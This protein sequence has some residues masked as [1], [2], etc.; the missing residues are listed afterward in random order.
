MHKI[1][2]TGVD[3]ADLQGVWRSRGYGFVLVIHKDDY[4]LYEESAVSCVA[5]YGGTLGDLAQR[6]TDLEVSANRNSFSAKRNTGITRISYQRL[7][8][9]PASFSGVEIGSEHGPQINFDIFCQSMAEQYA[10]FELKGVDWS[11]LCTIHRPQIKPDTLPGA[12]FN[13]MVSMLRPLRDG[14]VRLL[15][16]VGNFASGSLPALYKR[17]AQELEAGEDTR[18]V[19]SFLAQLRE[20]LRE[21]IREDYIQ[22]KS[23]FAGDRLLEWGRLDERTGYLVIRAMAGQSGR[24][25]APQADLKVVDM[26]LLRLLAELGSTERLVIDLRANGGGYDGVALRLASYFIDRKRLA[27]SKVARNGDRL[28][29]VQ[30]ISVAPNPAGAY[31]GDIVVLT[32]ELTASAAEIFLLALLQRPGLTIIGEPTQGILSDTLERHLP[33]GW[34]LTLSNEI[35]RAYDGEHYEDCGIPPHIRIPFLGRRARGAGRDPMLEH[36]LRMP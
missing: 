7:Q 35:Y 30:R 21:T 34:L 6:Y 10:F 15:T 17:L 1:A 28:T 13:A 32:S 16:P 5:V 2:T 4:T 12:L 14:H 9:M 11:A 31:K 25:G 18:D 24:I 3:L 19:P 23:A 33:N 20:S 22:G 8:A 26:A 36:V 27:F 29:G